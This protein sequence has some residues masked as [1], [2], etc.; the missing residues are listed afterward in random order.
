[1]GSLVTD[2]DKRDPYQKGLQYQLEG[3]GMG[4]P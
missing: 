1:M 4:G 2:K 3:Q